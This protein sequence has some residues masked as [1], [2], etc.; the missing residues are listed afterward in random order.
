M[1]FSSGYQDGQEG[2]EGN[3][4]DVLRASQLHLVLGVLVSSPP[5]EQQGQLSLCPGLLFAARNLLSPKVRQTHTED[6]LS[7]GMLE[8]YAEKQLDI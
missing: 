4:F 7:Q 2:G 3:L 8:A 1:A 6:Q 5:S